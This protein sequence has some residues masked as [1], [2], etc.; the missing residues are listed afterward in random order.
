LNW[1]D[2]HLF[3]HV[4]TQG[5][6]RKAAQSLGVSHATVSRRLA[7]FEQALGVTLL[8]RRGTRY[9]RTPAGDDAFK[10]A[11]EVDNLFTS[12]DLRVAGKDTR[13]A[14]T[15]RVTFAEMFS[16]LIAPDLA[17]F[18]KLHPGIEL[19]VLGGQ[20]TLNLSQRDADV[21]LR[22]SN[23]PPENLVG[24]RF[25]DLFY[26]VYA[27]SDYIQRVGQQ[28]LA[29]HDWITWDASLG[30]NFL[31]LRWINQHIAKER[32]VAGANTPETMNEMLASGMGV[33]QISCMQAEPDPRLVRLTAAEYHA[34]GGIWLLTHQELRQTARIRVFLDFLGE[35]LTH[36]Q[37]HF[38]PPMVHN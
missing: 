18:A 22:V 15:I 5:S 33:G 30:S 28:P 1:D 2:Y 31:P 26:S 34:A 7:A 38:S 21:A 11:T 35:R 12:L 20:Q 24:R 8:E 23:N 3:L 14:G 32:L 4:A 37:D 9:V 19:Q 27:S 6:I 36:H 13:L 10:T 17:D 25:G 29:E 16:N